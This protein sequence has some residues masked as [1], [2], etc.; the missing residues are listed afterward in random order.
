MR[1][2]RFCPAPV[3]SV[4]DRCQETAMQKRKRSTRKQEIAE[5][6]SLGALWVAVI[7]GLLLIG[8]MLYSTSTSGPDFAES[9][10]DGGTTGSGTRP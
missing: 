5:A 3:F 6:P 7:G 4:N 9:T 8:G 10:I 1:W 2:N